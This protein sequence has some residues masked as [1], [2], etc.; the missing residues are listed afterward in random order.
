M[1]ATASVNLGS[2]H[3]SGNKFREYMCLQQIK[4]N[5]KY[6]TGRFCVSDFEFI[7]ATSIIGKVEANGVLG[8]GPNGG[9]NS[10]VQSLKMHGQ[11]PNQRAIVG[12]NFENPLDTDQ[13]ST[14]SLGEINYDEVE[15]GQDEVSYFTNLASDKYWGLLM[16]DFYYG[17][18]EMSGDHKAKIGIIDSGNTSIQ[19]P[20]SM[21]VKVMANMRA[22]ERSI[23]SSVVEGN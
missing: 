14:I 7:L 23:Y 4:T 8:L 9:E 6:S 10:F 21:Y 22:H 15:G 12:I 13:K 1:Q 3:F 11:F 5:R 19:I 20:Q 2:M 17:G 16:D 18:M